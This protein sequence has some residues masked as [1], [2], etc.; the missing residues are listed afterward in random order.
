MKIYSLNFAAHTTAIRSL[1]LENGIEHEIVET[2]LMAGAN[3]TPEFL[4]ANTHSLRFDL[5]LTGIV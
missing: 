4:K 2:N 5:R 3:K 1:C